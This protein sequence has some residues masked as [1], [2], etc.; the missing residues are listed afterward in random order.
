MK[1]LAKFNLI[2]FL[3]FA[4]GGFLIAQLSYSF[5]IDNARREVL[6]EAQLMIASASSVRDYISD[7][8][9]PLLQENPRHRVHFLPE[10]IPFFGATNTF[11]R[12]R[13][14]YPDYTYKEAALNPTN[15][16]DRASDWETDIIDELRDHPEEKQTVGVRETPS[17][18]SL[19][20]ARPIQATQECM[21]CHSQPSTAPRP[22]I[23]VYGSANGFGWKKNEIVG[24]QVVSVPMSVPIEIANHAYHRLLLFL[25][26]TMLLVILALDTSVYWFVIRPLRIVSETADRVSRGEKDVPPVEIKGRDEIATVA[27]SFN[28]MQVSLAKALRM[29]DEQ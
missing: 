23:A 15:P 16:E 26:L 4:A 21:E 18:P 10:T 20:L 27:A 12:L 29:F 2:L 24:A 11:N 28:R 25:V 7:D 6:Q 17:G 5:L 22:L 8:I 9:S 1:L 3:I 13:K 14:H 19:Y